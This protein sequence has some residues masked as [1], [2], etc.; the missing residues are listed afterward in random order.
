M[1]DIGVLKIRKSSLVSFALGFSGVVIMFILQTLNFHPGKIIRPLIEEA[2]TQNIR[3]EVINR[4]DKVKNDFK[5]KSNTGLVP[6]AHGASDIDGASAYVAVDFDSGSVIAEKNLDKKTSIASITKIM[7]AVVALDLADSNEVFTV[8]AKASKIIPT[9][10][11]VVPGQKMSVSEL[12]HAALLTSANDAVQVIADGIDKKYGDGTFVA[13][14]NDK[15]KILGLK[16]TRFTNP[17]GFDDP[18]H[19]SS[20][21]DIAVLIHYA[22]TNYPLISDIVKKDY[23]FLPADSNHKQFDL[24]NWNGLIGVYPETIGMKIGNTGRAGYTTSVVSERGGKKMI[25][26]VL[27]APGIKE[28][29]MWAAELLDLS[30]FESEKLL[31]INVTEEQLIA[32]YDTW[33]YW[34]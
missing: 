3:Q 15:A 17:Q 5:V 30:Y 26:V 29:D 14:M 6:K 19:Y 2:N 9:K 4:L 7:T 20:V 27:G 11:G 33:E 31:P 10:I 18:E 28:R 25:A 8:T 13:S 16:N 24:Y 23:H 1:I 12:L 32:K 34:N 22:L 21:S